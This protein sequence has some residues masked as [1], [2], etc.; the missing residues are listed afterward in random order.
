MMKKV[1]YAEDEFTNR[2]ILEI[3]CR[4]MNLECILAEDGLQALELYRKESPDLVILDQ[5]MP[6][7][8][9]DIV[10]E[11]IRKKDKLTPL[12]AITSDDEAVSLLEE[13]GFNRVLVKPV[14]N[15]DYESLLNTYLE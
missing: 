13:T 2:K 10:A 3:I 5:Y 8:N 4:K 15:K 1:L 7:Y 14:K 6:G 9:G 12:V 11:K